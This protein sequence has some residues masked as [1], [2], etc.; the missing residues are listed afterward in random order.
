MKTENQISFQPKAG[1]LHKEL[2]EI[3]QGNLDAD[4]LLNILKNISATYNLKKI[5]LEIIDSEERLSQ[6]SNHSYLHSN[7]FDKIVI[8]SFSEFG[9]KLRLHIWWNENNHIEESTVHNH[10]WDF[11]S[12]LIVGSYAMKLF[13]ESKTDGEEYLKTFYPTLAKSEQLKP[14][15]ETKK[16]KLSCYKEQT[17]QANTFYAL[18][19]NK[20]HSVVMPK[21]VAAS[22]VLQGK[23]IADMTTVYAKNDSIL[24]NPFDIKYFTT[25]QIK[26]K[27]TDLC[28]LL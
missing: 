13:R 25:D 5:L 14:I 12:H 1:I 17:F 10:P 26:T 2:S 3:N 18:D 24:N 23:H 19:H 11:A 21:H 9:L 20:F 28:I 7:G 8:D 27:L 16:V 15:I 6:L 22:L 4:A